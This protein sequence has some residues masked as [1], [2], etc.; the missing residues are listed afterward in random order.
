MHE[1]GEIV[2]CPGVM[3]RYLCHNFI[4]YVEAKIILQNK[5][6]S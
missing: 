4:V 3:R 1:I 6:S 2:Q 5:M